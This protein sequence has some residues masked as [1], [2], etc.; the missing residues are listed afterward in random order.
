MLEPAVRFEPADRAKLRVRSAAR[1]DDVRVVGVGEPVRPGA[2]RG[3]DGAL[4]QAEGGLVGSEKGEKLWDRDRGLGVGDGM[5]ASVV[6]REPES[7]GLRER[8]EELGSFDIRAAK[9]EMGV[10]RPAHRAGGQERA[11]QV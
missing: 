7:L 11:A 10:P 3:N 8:G 6:D 5:T 9:L 4:L 1:A 2:G